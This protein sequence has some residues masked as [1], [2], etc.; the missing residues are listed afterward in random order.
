MAEAVSS[1]MEM[2]CATVT[3]D[4]FVCTNRDDSGGEGAMVAEANELAEASDIETE[5]NKKRT[6]EL[7]CSREAIAAKALLHA[8]MLVR[9]TVFLCIARN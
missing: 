5:A 4:T 6:E 2:M 9:R 7:R 3:R 1:V 8:W